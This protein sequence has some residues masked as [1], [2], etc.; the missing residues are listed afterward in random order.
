VE[1]RF[2]TKGSAMTH[3]C[4]PSCRLRFTPAAAA[5]LVACPECGEKLQS[6]GTRQSMLGFRLFDVEETLPALPQARAVSLPI[7]RPPGARR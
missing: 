3:S 5:Y 6:T 4:C 1:S 2:P 7:S